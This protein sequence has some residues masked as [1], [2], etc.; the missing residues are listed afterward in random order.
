MTTRSD[1]GSV[2]VSV[3]MLFGFMAVLFALALIFET[4]AYWHA[5]NVFDD[6]AAEGARVAAAFD[7][8]CADGIAAATTMVRD[9]AGSWGRSATVT[10]VDG[11]VVTVTII[12]RTA[13]ILGP[14]MG[15]Q[16]RVSESA[17]KEG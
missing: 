11:P 7:G 15:M 4:V 9:T 8:S 2:D 5:R 3:Q 14:A 13:G 17:P 1:R 10:C 6:A 16:A 12:G